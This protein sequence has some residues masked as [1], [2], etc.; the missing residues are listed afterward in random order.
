MYTPSKS[1]CEPF[2]LNKEHI[3]RILEIIEKR[4]PSGDSDYFDPIFSYKRLD[5]YSHETND[6]N[7]LFHEDN[8]GNVRIVQ[9]EIHS[10][11]FLIA[12]DGLNYKITF[13]S[14]ENKD[15]FRSG[16]ALFKSIEIEVKG[17]NRDIAELL[18]SDLDKYIENTIVFS[19]NRWLV[20]LLKT[21]ESPY[22]L[23]FVPFLTLFPLVKIMLNS[24]SNDISKIIDE[25]LLSQDIEVKLDAILLYYQNIQAPMA[26]GGI[27]NMISVVCLVVIVF[28]LLFGGRLLTKL[29]SLYPFVFDFGVSV[30][31]Y[32]SRI[33]ILK[34]MIGI[35][36][37][38]ALGVIGNFLYDFL[39][40][41]L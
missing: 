26:F 21:I 4:R 13:T 11:H 10:E 34:W 27:S 19:K 32:Q 37:S 1:I 9:L 40:Q 25:A 16:F 12:D 38:L 24:S 2:V 39:I 28:L 5:D 6:V 15:E 29:H 8:C 35:V 20:K 14:F 33:R 3:L 17:E 36:G 22:S 23:L 7:A 41:F 18:F 31:N 30:E